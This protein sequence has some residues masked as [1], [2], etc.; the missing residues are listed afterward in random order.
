MAKVVLAAVAGLAAVAA[1]TAA[2]GEYVVQQGDKLVQI[3]RDR[4]GDERRWKEL[5]ELNKLAPPYALHVGQRLVLPAGWP[6]TAPAGATSRPAGSAARMAA[7]D[8]STSPPAPLPAAR[9]FRTNRRGARS[10]AAGTAP[11]TQPSALPAAAAASN[12]IPPWLVP[13]LPAFL[14][15]FGALAIGLVFVA[16]ALVWWVFF[17]VCLRGACWFALVDATFGACFRLALYLV[18]LGA[19][20]AAIGLVLPFVGAAGISVLPM[21]ALGAVAVLAYFVV[22]LVVARQVLGCQWRSVVTVLVMATFVSDLLA[23]GVAV[24]AFVLTATMTVAG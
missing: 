17:A 13:Y 20:C 15:S 21:I 10:P 1:T 16:G 19:G 4:V 22:S 11:E 3:A 6:T 24:G 2:A 12:G 8:P 23:A 7:G 9:A 5:A 18:L 14:V